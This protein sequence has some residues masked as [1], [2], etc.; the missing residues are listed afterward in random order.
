M[1]RGWDSKAVESQIQEAVQ[2]QVTAEPT[3]S[4]SE[5]FEKQHKLGNLQLIRSQLLEQLSRARSV[6]HRQMLHQSLREIEEQIAA[7]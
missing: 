2:M 7:L 6:S 3:L 5:A 1:A 4:S